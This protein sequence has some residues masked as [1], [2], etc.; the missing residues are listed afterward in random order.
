M[1]NTMTETQIRKAAQKIARKASALRRAGRI[2][3]ARRVVDEAA[4]NVAAMRAAG[5]V[6]A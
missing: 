2:E 4:A 5:R 3:E 6:V 1:T